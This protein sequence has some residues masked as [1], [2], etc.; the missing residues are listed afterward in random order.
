MDEK[1]GNGNVMC[2]REKFVE[3]DARIFRSTRKSPQSLC[4]GDLCFKGKSSRFILI[5]FWKCTNASFFLRA[6]NTWITAYNISRIYCNVGRLS[7]GIFLR[8]WLVNS[9]GSPC[10]HYWQRG[11]KRQTLPPELF[12][13]LREVLKRENSVILITSS[14][15]NVNL[16][17]LRPVSSV[18]TDALRKIIVTFLCLIITNVIYTFIILCCCTYSKAQD[19]WMQLCQRMDVWRR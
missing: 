16:I 10:L 12:D 15:Y 11:K 2:R 4:T 8:R 19:V 9:T 18:T 14:T 17:S 3:I 1:C 6:L 7:L 5:G 13:N